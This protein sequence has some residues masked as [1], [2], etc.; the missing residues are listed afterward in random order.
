[1]PGGKAAYPST[2]LM[3]ATLAQVAGVENIVVVTPP[4]PEGVNPSILAA[5]QLTG[6][7]HVYQVGAHKVLLLWL[8]V[9][10]QFQ[11]SIK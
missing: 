2:V 11:R 8:L 4:Q 1:M 10:K 6:V 3:T 7:H 9:P 5:C